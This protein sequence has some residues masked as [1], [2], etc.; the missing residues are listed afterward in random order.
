MTRVY[1]SE[2]LFGIPKI[3]DY[4]Q[5]DVYK[6]LRL[7]SNLIFYFIRKIIYN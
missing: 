2:L 6:F 5:N 3:G 1:I 7:K 4:L